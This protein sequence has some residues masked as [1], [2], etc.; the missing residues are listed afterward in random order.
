MSLNQDNRLR[1]ARNLGLAPQRRLSNQIQAQDPEDL[2]RFEVR[3]GSSFEAS[4]KATK[5]ANLNLA[6]WRATAPVG[7]LLRQIGQSEFRNLTASQRNRNLTLV[8]A[9]SSTKS[10]TAQLEPGIY[11]LRVFRQS[12]QSRY[13]LTTR[14]VPIAAGSLPL[15]NSAVNPVNNAPN[16]SPNSSPN[17]P[18][19]NPPNNSSNSPSNS[20]SSN[21]GNNPPSNPPS[22]SSRPPNNPSG[23]STS[24]PP[25]SPDRNSR[26]PRVVNVTASPVTIRQQPNY[27]FSVTYSDDQALNL[28]SIDSNDLVITAANGFR[29]P[30]RL[31]STAP[32]GNSATATYEITAPLGSWAASNNGTYQIVL[33]PRQISDNSGNLAASG[34]IGSFQIEIASPFSPTSGYG[35]VNAAAAVARAVG[36]TAF[37]DTADGLDP[38]LFGVD[39]V[40][41]PEA[42]S[43]G[44]RGQGV[45]V[46]V[47]DTGV[48]YFTPLLS[49]SIWQNLGETP[50]DGI[51]N[52]RNGYID[53]FRGWDFV[54]NR[55]IP[56]DDDPDG[57][58]TFVS[59]IVTDAGLGI[60][61]DAKVMP[62]KIASFNDPSPP[63]ERVALAM[64][65]AVNNGARII[66]LSFA[67][68]LRPTV[69]LQQAIR[70]ARQRGVLLVVAA[71]NRGSLDSEPAEPGLF[72]AE[73]DLGIAAGAIDRNNA[74]AAFSN[75]AGS[76][77]IN[78]LVAPGVNVY[79]TALDGGEPAQLSGT[80]FAAPAIASVAAL[81]L[82]ANPS[83]TPDQIEQ[84]LI[85][86]ATPV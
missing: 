8:Q 21:S 49:D 68:P 42:W 76:R 1:G 11:F 39:Q 65:Y 86:T 66:N 62:V 14:L 75:P 63:D 50:N 28:S 57:H 51:D 80:S 27:R 74:F 53:D 18:S 4:L 55:N 64:D 6:L 70:S 17:S 34:P 40:K 67:G 38:R 10:I 23:N 56:I 32:T 7:R 59:G 72:T 77:P 5:T 58:G 69:R 33:Q 36:Q 3:Q 20:S 79:S 15:N 12:G 2:F 30:A 44:Y 41:A 81:M 22:N 60:A 29:Q 71:G 45:V 48:N 19:N 52:D 9:G 78:Y 73:T 26:P 61:P 37:P 54:S 35:L 85:D 83:L 31:V 13:Q 82:S 25:A 43:Q 46:A 47:I 16:N 24:N 84:I